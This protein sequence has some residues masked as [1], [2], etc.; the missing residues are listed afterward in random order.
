MPPCSFAPAALHDAPRSPS[1]IWEKAGEEE[2]GRGGREKGE[3]GREGKDQEGRMIER[4][5]SGRNGKME[6]RKECKPDT[7]DCV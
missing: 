6:N 7:M 1:S 3:V 2:G 5:K 4:R